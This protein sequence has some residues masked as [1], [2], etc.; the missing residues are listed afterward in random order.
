MK[1]GTKD[2]VR[3]CSIALVLMVSLSAAFRVWMAFQSKARH[4][5]A[6]GPANSKRLPDGMDGLTALLQKPLDR[7]TVEDRKCEPALHSWLLGH[8][9]VVLPWEWSSAAICKDVRGYANAWV[10]L[11][12]SERKG[13]NAILREID[14]RIELVQDAG[15]IARR[16]HAHE[17]NELERLTAVFATN[18]YPAEVTRNM[19]SKGRFWGW[20][21]VEETIQV[22]DVQAAYA[23]LESIRSGADRQKSTVRQMD[24]SRETLETNEAAAKKLVS[25]LDDIVQAFK[26]CDGAT[27]PTPGIHDRALSFLAACIKSCVTLREYRPDACAQR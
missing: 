19:L 16:Q 13:L 4:E 24:M 12:E 23:L 9:K 1:S 15:G 11:L 18:S 3:T 14:K 22:K 2:I 7:W 8:S 6:A 25:D 5:S 21:T 27:G 26:Q 17:T 20:N 10:S